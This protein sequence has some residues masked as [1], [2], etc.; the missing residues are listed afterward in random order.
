MAEPNKV[1]VVLGPTATG[2]TK[3][4]VCLA[5]EFNGEIISADS[6]Q[7]YKGMDVGTGKDLKEYTVQSPE[8]RVNKIKYHLIDVVS[9][10]VDFNVAKFQKLAYA[11]IDDI[12]ARGKT[13]IIVG[14]TGLYI[15]AVVEGY[16]FNRVHSPESTVRSVGV[17]SK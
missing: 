6:R 2:N 12:L 17:G 9:P 11:A 1:I 15:N 10:K 14:G 5:L 13:P 16:Q 3:V 4:G 8:S 7:V